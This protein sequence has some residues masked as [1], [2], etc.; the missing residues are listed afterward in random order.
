MHIYNEK[1]LLSDYKEEM[2]SRGDCCRAIVF[3]SGHN[4]VGIVVGNTCTREE[5]YILEIS[6]EKIEPY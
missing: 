4:Y 5:K 2:V 1:W 6:I 3:V